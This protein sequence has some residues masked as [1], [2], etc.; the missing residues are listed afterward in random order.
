LQYDH[1]LRFYHAD[2]ERILFYG[3]T[4]PD[5]SN[6]VLVVINLDPHHVQSGWVRMPLYE[7]GLRP[8]EPYQVHDLLTNAH[9]L[10]YGEN[11][12]VHLPPDA[13]AHVLRVRRRVKTER[14]FDYF[15]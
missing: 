9:F 11:N 13:P 2:N 6:I 1:R 15:M 14:D 12:Y 4:L 3:K 10:W 7:L 5:L 8:D